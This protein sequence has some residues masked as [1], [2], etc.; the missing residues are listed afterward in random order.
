MSNRYIDIGNVPNLTRKEWDAIIARLRSADNLVRTVK[1][2]HHPNETA[3][4]YLELINKA[5]AEYEGKEK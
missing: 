5:I 3:M 1:R 2:I 4:Q